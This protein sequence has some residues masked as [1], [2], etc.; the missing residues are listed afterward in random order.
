MLRLSWATFT[1]H[2]RLF[3]GAVLSVALGVALVQS[4]LL[5]LAATGKPKIPHGASAQ[6]AASIREGYVGA[7]TLLGMTVLLAGFLAV[8][9]VSSTFAFTVAQRRKDLALLRLAGASRT[10]L[11]GL[12]LSEALLLG[13]VGTVLG[14]VLGF[15]ATWAQSWLLI[16]LGFLPSGF[17]PGWAAGVLVASVGVGMGVAFLGVLAASWRAA[18]VRPLEALRE[19]GAAARVMT[20]ARWFFGLT[21][22]AFSVWL[23]VVAQ[24]ADI[25]G[26]M[27][28]A[29][30]VSISGAVSLSL[31][32]PLLV[33]LVGRALG[34]LLRT[35]TLGELAQANLR[36]GVRRSAS[37]AA[38]LIVLVSL[39]IGLAG[40]LG[41][42]AKAIGL[43]QRHLTTGDLVVDSTATD[44][45]RLAAIPGVLTASPEFP[46]KMAVTFGHRTTY[47]GIVAVDPSAYQRTHRPVRG[48]ERLRGRTIAL[49][50]GMS[51]EG[52]RVGSKVTVRFGGQK[53]RLRI[54]AAV[55]PTLENYAANYL[56]PRDL[57][58]VGTTAQ[59]VVRATE[60]SAVAGRI[61]ADRIGRVRTVAQWAD[62]KAAAEERGSLSILAVLMGMAGLY[63]A[64]AVIN[65]VVIAGAERRAEFATARVSGLTRGQVVRM[66]LVES[67]AVTLIGLALGCVVAFGALSGGPV[68]AIPWTLLAALSAG[69]FVVTS[70]ASVWT[71]LSATR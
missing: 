63:A 55:P 7:A 2:W 60:P 43:E 21:S 13:V 30:T 52:I 64:V 16:A 36:D 18:K 24:S 6:T 4:S 69:A 34:L 10:Q 37:T 9:I 51:R 32:S 46:V 45:D 66:A 65:A 27:L 67:A 23:V 39:L 47:T 61:R 57:A 35:G 3:A 28:V 56:V 70:A 54:V 17:T 8:F 19:V 68:I 62:D 71:T 42:L 38:P 5:V 1:D 15:P 11:V 59:T 41:S 44:A 22:L 20:V 33:P 25:L 31:L 49:A 53:M 26:A 14:V 48:L 29:I 12:L 40:T 50:P 58:P